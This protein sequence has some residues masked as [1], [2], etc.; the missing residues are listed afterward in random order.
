MRTLVDFKRKK[1]RTET[2]INTLNGTSYHHRPGNVEYW[3]KSSMLPMQFTNQKESY[4]VTCQ[5]L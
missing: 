2:K 5:N 1:Q 4:E 3:V